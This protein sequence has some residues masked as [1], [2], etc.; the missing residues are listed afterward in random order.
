MNTDIEP[1]GRLN[2]LKN[3]KNVEW[4]IKKEI[5]LLTDFN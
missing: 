3:Q 4:L 2:K 5:F 1:A